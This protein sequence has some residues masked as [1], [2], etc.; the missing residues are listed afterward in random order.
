[1][2]D[3]FLYSI[4]TLPNYN[5]DN[6]FNFVTSGED[7][8][9]RILSS[10]SNNPIQTL[11][12]PCQ[13]IWCCISLPNSD[14]VLA[15]SD[16]TIRLFTQDE[17]RMANSAER[18]EFERELASFTMPTKADE[19]LSKIDRSKLPGV[20]AL[21]THG[22]SDG[23]ILLINN[24]NETEVYSWNL[25]ECRWVKIG[26]AIEPE[27][28]PT[29]KVFY[30]NKEYDYVFD[31]DLDDNRKL[32]LPYNNGQDPYIVA[33][34]FI[35]KND[36]SQHF[37][38]EIALFIINN[39]AQNKASENTSGYCDPFTG[40]SR[41]TPSSTATANSS[42][43]ALRDPFTGESRYT[44]SN[45]SFN[46]QPSQQTYMDPFTGA[47]SYY[48]AAHSSK[49]STKINE[50]YPQKSFVLFDQRNLKPI[51][52]KIASLCASNPCFDELTL[53]VKKMSTD[54][55]G[56]I[57]SSDYDIILRVLK[58]WK[59]GDYF[60]FSISIIF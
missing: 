57:T 41:Y 23:K 24:N 55:N 39:T 48:S 28:T 8:S 9:V 42:A 59:P 45:G 21:L 17:S 50:Y 53:F 38:D 37:L 31:I 44:P 16:G 14:L 27:T 29:S 3:S 4:N 43:Q 25:A 51:V 52:D 32:K 35:H 13:S 5:T 6:E 12:L 58:T 30:N 47:S 15:C 20:E 33:Q 22:E 19:K 1:M 7:R 26:T 18:E 11:V 46:N 36:L 60:L 54:I 56:K 40:G 34:E 2:S 10:K 49:V